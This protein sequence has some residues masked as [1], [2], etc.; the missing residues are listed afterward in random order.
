[1]SFARPRFTEI[2]LDFIVATAAPEAGDADRLKR[3]VVEDADFRS[4][5]VSDERV[6]ERVMADDEM[7]VRISP[8]LYF[9]V[10][11]RK[12]QTELDV[13]SHT[14]ERAGSQRV[15]VFDA[16]EASELLARPGIVEYLADMLSSF[17]RVRSYTTRVRVRPRVWRRIRFNDMD[18]DSLHRMAANTDE[19]QRFP[20]YKRIADVCL[21]VLGIFP[22]H[23]QFDYRYASSGQIRP[24]T[25]GRLRRSMEAYEEE[26]TRA[27]KLAAE[28]G[29]AVYLGLSEVM[30][31]LQEHFNTATKPLNFIS[32]HYLHLR[33]RSLFEIDGQ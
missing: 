29:S 26:G 7:F 1:M 12:A 14:F 17:T 18:V 16:R 27:Y 2:D 25:T 3:L 28:H 21:F 11:L 32:D 13:S 19:E 31:T 9:E 23:A 24:M 20:I 5:L 22:E 8:H 4:G 10:L 6:F 33:K 15:A 30:L